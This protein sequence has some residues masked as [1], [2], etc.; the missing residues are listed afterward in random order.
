MA[1]TCAQHPDVPALYRC[2]G[3]EKHL[4]GDCIEESHAL[5]LCRLC[6]ERALPL[7]ESRPASVK[8]LAKERQVTG[9]YSLT[10]ALFYPF[11]GTGLSLFLA[12]LF[13]MM[14]IWFLRILII[15]GCIAGVLNLA[16]WLMIF[17]LQ[18]KIVRS[19]AEGDNELPDW[20]DFLDFGSLLQDLVTALAVYT[21]VIFAVAYYFAA[22]GA[23]G[24]GLLEPRFSFWFGFTVV[25][26]LGTA[27]AV[28]AFGAAGTYSRIRVLYVHCH[29]QGFLAAGA[30]AVHVTNL[31]F[32]VGA[33]G[34]V[35][36]RI[37]E[38]TV[39]Y[40]GPA[41]SSAV[42]TYCMFVLPH[43]SGLVFRRH[44]KRMDMLYWARYGG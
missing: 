1:E 44:T 2:E 18:F 33:A 20:P 17:G 10:D 11:R 26:W 43:L 25:L 6:G 24:S 27:F 28:M 19:T 3:C 41:L 14:V 38:G 32:A 13:C 5:L 16:L 7:D 29:A 22:G 31:V 35:I 15:T 8:A 36:P 21:V 4:C 12:V 42:V 23:L 39:P 37:L 40:V 34:L 30:D 9:P